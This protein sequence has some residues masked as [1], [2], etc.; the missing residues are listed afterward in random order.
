MR[1]VTHSRYAHVGVVLDE[2]GERVVWEAFGPVGPTPL[3]KWLDRG[4]GRQAAVY[5]P[6]GGLATH[7]TAIAR[8][9]QAMRGL[10]Y[11]GDYQWDDERIYCSELY[12]KAV[13]RATGEEH[14]TPHP[15]GPGAFGRHAETIRRLSK[16]RL[17]EQ[18][19]MV[20]PL[21]LTRSGELAR[22]VDELAD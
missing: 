7:R 9:V 22:V 13:R 20:S 16:G 1:E 2:G 15:L 19:P 5:R 10:P 6:T 18:T 11:D 8:E 4:R 14:F 21:D 12:A 3:A 17:T